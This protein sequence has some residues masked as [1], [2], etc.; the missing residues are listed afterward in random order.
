NLGPPVASIHNVV[1]ITAARGARCPRHPAMMVQARR[2][3]KKIP[4]C[5]HASHPTPPTHASPECPHAH[6]SPGGASMQRLTKPD[7]GKA[8]SDV[9]TATISLVRGVVSGSRTAS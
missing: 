5:P 1:A 2:P 7:D 9:V 3:G 4:E 8:P 6:A